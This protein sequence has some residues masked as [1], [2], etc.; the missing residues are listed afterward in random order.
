MIEGGKMIQYGAKALPEGGW[1]TIPRPYAKGAMLIGDS[2]SFLNPM[3]LKGI[4]TAMKTGM[5]R[6]QRRRSSSCGASTST[7]N[8]HGHTAG[9]HGHDD[10]AAHRRPRFA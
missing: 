1:N 8:A 6:R 10:H 7:A 3:R 5:P 2:A 9:G 4:H